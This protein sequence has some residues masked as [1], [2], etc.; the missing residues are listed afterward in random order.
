MP[1]RSTRQTASVRVPLLLPEN[2]AAAILAV[3]DAIS[4]VQ[5]AAFF[6]TGPYGSGKST[7]LKILAELAATQGSEPEIDFDPRE[8]RLRDL[9]VRRVFEDHRI[10]CSSISLD[11]KREQSVQAAIEMSIRDA[12]PRVLPQGAS[13]VNDPLAVRAG[14]CLD[15]H[16]VLL[17]LV[18]ELSSF[19]NAKEASAAAAD[20]QFLLRL[21]ELTASGDLP[22]VM[23]M[24]VR[25]NIIA[26]DP[27]YSALG[28]KLAD[29]Y[30][31]LS[32]YLE[33]ALSGHHS[34]DTLEFQEPAP[35]EP[36]SARLMTAIAYYEGVL[37]GAPD[38][39]WARENLAYAQTAFVE[40]ELTL[41]AARSAWAEHNYD[42][43]IELYNRALAKDSANSEAQRYVERAERIQDLVRSAEQDLRKNRL[44]AAFHGFA[45]ALD[46]DHANGK[47]QARQAEARDTAIAS[48]LSEAEV[49][50]SKGDFRAALRCYRAILSIA[51]ERAD[52][53]LRF[54][55][56]SDRLNKEPARKRRRSER[57]Y[58]RAASVLDEEV[59]YCLASPPPLFSRLYE[60]DP[61]D[62]ARNLARLV[63]GYCDWDEVERHIQR[64]KIQG[65]TRETRLLELCVKD[66]PLEILRDTIPAGKLLK[67]A[68]DLGLPEDENESIEGLRGRVLLKLGFRLPQKPS[69]I[70]VYRERAGQLRAELN[71]CDDRSQVIGIGTSGC[72]DIAEP[73]L[74]DLVHFYCTALMGSDYEGLLAQQ[75]LLPPASRHGLASLTFGQKIGLV[76]ELNRYIKTNQD[77][78]Q[79]M[80]A[81]FGRD[82]ILN[83]SRHVQKFLDPMCTRRNSLAHPEGAAT[84]VLKKAAEEALDLL[85][86]LLQQ[87]EEQTI[88]PPLVVVVARHIDAYGRLTHECVDD[89]GRPER[90]FTTM[91]LTI[92]AEY[93]LH[94]ESNPYRVDPII[95]AKQ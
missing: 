17:I 51:P 53:L 90:V 18:D 77:L 82:W 4:R 47:L 73:V 49:A 28:P 33:G 8:A 93:F 31:M 87:L 10:A 6:L 42:E 52:I 13:L 71:L 59:P 21:G 45:Q 65:R 68:E 19:L 7:V 43:A 20:L 34:L 2:Q 75:S 5:P 11:D 66:D 58:E 41:M 64:K 46:L 54:N 94:F 3:S 44:V 92:G 81:W 86:Q 48:L 62:P 26:L 39:A 16:D 72:N 29:R 69:G 83:N 23:V 12:Y 57:Q 56:A 76:K 78:R 63:G 79:H 1:K 38:A 14:L 50:E 37:K 89:R 25:D 67:L 32:L 40:T 85:S 61:A 27:A 15:N 88:Y 80:Q 55:V 22:A 30:S 9:G 36:Y 24:A 95:V 74:K 84:E 60:F 35:R 91:D 70:A